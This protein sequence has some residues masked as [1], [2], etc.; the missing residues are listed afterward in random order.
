MTD[1]IKQG[2][3]RLRPRS[4]T[5]YVSQ[6]RTVLSMSNDGFIHQG[7]EHG[8]IVSETRLLSLYEY[9]IDGKDLMPVAISNVE[10]HTWLGYYIFLP[11]ELHGELDEGSGMLDEMTQHTLELKI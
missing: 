4:D 3:I 1:R 2:L 6:N 8:L 9:R 5:I 7:V 10:Q 11:Q